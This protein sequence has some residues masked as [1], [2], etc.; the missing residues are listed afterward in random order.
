MRTREFQRLM[1]K[2]DNVNRN[3]KLAS[4]IQK[5]KSE[6]PKYPDLNSLEKFVAH[7]K[8]ICLQQ[9]LHN[10]SGCSTKK[11]NV[12][13]SIG[14]KKDRKKMI[15]AGVP[16]ERV[17]L[18]NMKLSD[19][20]ITARYLGITDIFG[21]KSRLVD[22]ILKRQF[23]LKKEGKLIETPKGYKLNLGGG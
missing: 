11:R 10:C 2:L 9:P 1:K 22:L 20:W 6:Q 5:E 8:V 17:I 21:S 15:C 13:W 4:F 16:Y 12:C 23:E 3:I 19:L 18:G 7:H 14:V